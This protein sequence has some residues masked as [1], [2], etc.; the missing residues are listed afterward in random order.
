MLAIFSAALCV[1]T[2]VSGCAGAIAPP[3][4]SASSPAASPGCRTGAL[5]MLQ[6][7]SL[8]GVQF[9]SAARG[10]VVGQDKILATTDG[11]RHW[12]EQ[13]S[14]QFNL[15]SVDFT[16]SRVGWAVGTRTVLAT[17]D[18]G[19][20]W[21]TLPEPCP[22]IRSVHF[23]SRRIGFAVAGGRDFS[24]IGP[25]APEVAGVALTTDDG[26]RHWR[27]LSTPADAQTICFSNPHDGWLGADGRLYRTTDEGQRWRQATAGIAPISARYPYTMIVQCTGDGSTWAVDVGPGAASS[28][29]PHVGYYASQAGAVPIFAEQY[30]PHP[31]ARVS[32]ESPGA[33]A[34]PFSAI[35]P[36]TAAYIDE[37]APCGQGTAPWDLVTGSGASLTREGNVG[38]LNYPEAA[39]FL[40]L[41]VGWVVGVVNHFNATG[42]TGQYQRI[43]FTDDAG[44]TW[45][46]QYTGPNTAR[47]G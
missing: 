19:A 26:G 38:E 11:G 46:I 24:D 40:S 25:A 23:V 30:F 32:A 9:V 42:I 13:K 4:V 22:L 15:T 17:F 5:P 3:T 31:G 36:S 20:H 18:G 10:W 35:S 16:S 45:H 7:G 34:G 39:A 14:G 2:F 29:Q 41:Q 1:T 47:P 33:Y 12:A 8:T 6:A 43:V 44:R 27:V 37:C 21:A 28:Q